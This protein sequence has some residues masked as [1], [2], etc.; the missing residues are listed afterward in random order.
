MAKISTYPIISSP[1]F[2]DLLIGTDVDNLNETK[3][4]TIGD[5]AD[6]I[7]VGSYV[8]YT[9]AIANVDLGLFGI[10]AS[11]FIYSGGTSSQFLKADGS[12]DSTSYQVAGNYLTGLSGE[13]TAT[14]PN[15]ANV[16]LNNASVIGKVLTGLTIS[17]G[18]IYDT[19]SILTAFGKVQ[20]QI[21]SIVSGLD[22][23]GT[24][25][26]STN[27]P[28]LS[29]G[30]GANGDYYVVGVAGNTS[31][32]GITDWNVG[33]WAI[34]NGSTWQKI[35]NTDTVVS[36]NGKVGIVV[37][38]TTDISEGTNLY[39]TDDRSRGAIS[40]TTTGDSGASTYSNV[41]GI[42]NI[43]NYSISGLGGVPSSRQL[44]INGTAYDLSVDRSWSVGTVTSIGTSGPLT[45]G[46]ITGSG[47][48]GI[49][50]A[51]ASSDGYLS[52]TDWNTFNNKQNALTNPVTGIGT[53]YYLPMWTG[54]SSLG[55]SII[56]YSSNVVNFNFD[57]ASGA[58][59]NYI[60]RDGVDYTYTIQMNNFGT[61]QT[62]HTY[63]DGNIIQRIGLND[64]S[65]NLSTGQLVLPYYTA[66][67]SFVGTAA[68]YLGFDASGNILTVAIPS[69]AGYVP[70]TGA[71]GNV[72][73]GEY[74]IAAGQVAFDQTP[75]GTAG[76][77]I[78]R[79]NDADG[80]LD[81][82]LKGGNVTLQIGQEQ[83]AYVVNKSGINLLESAYQVVKVTDAQGQRLAVDLA[84]GNNDL[85]SADTIGIVTENINNNQEGF[86]T[87]S[88]IVRG[89]NTTGS[90]QGETW[91]DGDILYLSP[92][93]A[94]NIT[95]IKP[96][97]PNHTVILGYVV[98]AH[99][100]NGKIFVKCDNGYEIGELH[101]CYLPSPSNND[102]I[103]WNSANGRYQNNSIVGAL[104]YTPYNATNPSGFVNYNLYT[105]DGTL[106]GDRY[107]NGNSKN[108]WIND[109]NTLRVTTG[110]AGTNQVAL[111]E[112][113]EPYIN[114]KATGGSNPASLFLSP[115][116]GVNGTIQNRTGGGLEFY[117]GAIPS[118][119]ATITPLTN[120]LLGTSI[121]TG[122]RCQI[123][124]SSAD[125]HLNVWGATA[126][127]I[128]I[129]NAAT[130]ATQR[131]VVG[132][133]TAT[134]N[135]I[136][137]ASAGDI[138]LT[139]QSSSPLLFGANATEAMRIS[140]SANVLINKTADGGQPLQ[141]SGNVNLQSLPT[142][143]TGLVSG[144][145]WNDSGT[146][147]IV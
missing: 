7:I 115:S 107:I 31:L 100:V 35:D 81:I 32:D 134:N 129:D 122:Y 40:L 86:I 97:A 103:F 139:T 116:A 142:S 45:G 113:V 29:S 16:V 39:Y 20:N 77:G 73:L 127:S 21:N 78:L 66:T 69:L 60:N 91:A 114:I 99:G 33:D 137:G 88:G 98:Y 34:F 105:S 24:W 65:R 10:T 89:I 80:T 119:A 147:K 67:S 47:T 120:L 6:L 19:D 75:T 41:T 46:T 94:G 140:I 138:C 53:V 118:L 59:V 56:S 131:F 92:T 50:Q 74:Q 145:I 9:G 18:T 49:T 27:T 125:S 90:L 36:V 84:Q 30:V 130:A 48:I 25:N 26:A 146:L 93:V 96:I 22:Y 82:G 117:V 5:I 11:S 44:T 123:T 83:V 87:T 111:F 79:W 126:P 1:T 68:G 64:I 76:V 52:S 101:D 102:G 144:D 70:Y 61:R 135:F 54:S 136:I 62:Y 72:N 13:A 95:N 112:S 104:G 42:L 15:V 17:G 106:A 43:P 2:N 37:L 51:G 14:G 28:S 12:I 121:D 23:Q 8:P 128:R 58:T 143:A 132:L 133:A 124:S 55:D 57:S 141:V 108:L 109:I 3:N 85:N 71:T 4:F 63:T 110:L 38:T